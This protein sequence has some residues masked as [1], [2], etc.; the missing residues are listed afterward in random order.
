MIGFHLGTLLFLALL[1]F[2]GLAFFEL[3]SGFIGSGLP[4]S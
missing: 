4:F 2:F 3:L 1:P